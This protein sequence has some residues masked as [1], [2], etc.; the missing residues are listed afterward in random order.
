M[1]TIHD[2]GEHDDGMIT[3]NEGICTAMTQIMNIV[4]SSW[5]LLCRIWIC[6]CTKEEKESREMGVSSQQ[7][8]PSQAEKKIDQ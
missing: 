8:Q 2:C 6:C 1:C 5:L 4:N 7:R 3:N